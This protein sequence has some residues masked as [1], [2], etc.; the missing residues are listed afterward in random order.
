MSRQ[1]KA[2]RIQNIYYCSIDNIDITGPR[3]SY[4]KSRIFCSELKYSAVSS[5]FF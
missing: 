3:T 5:A 1:W 2:Y 4:V